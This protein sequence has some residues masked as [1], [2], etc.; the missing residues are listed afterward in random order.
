MNMRPYRMIAALLVLCV[1]AILVIQALWIN[2]FYSEKRESF[3]RS[4]YASLEQVARRLDERKGIQQI[5]GDLLTDST[6]IYRR[7]NHVEVRRV[8]S[9][10]GVNHEEIISTT[11]SAYS[12]NGS[13]DSVKKIMDEL[14][15][16]SP[17][18]IKK[19]ELKGIYGAAAREDKAKE[20]DID[21]L[22]N[23]MML[24]IKVL[25]V[26]ENN[27]DTLHNIIQRALANKGLF[28]PFE[29]LIK[30]TGKGRDTEVAR[31]KGYNPQQM[32]YTS[33]LSAD[34]IFNA[35][36]FVLLQFPAAGGFVLSG[37]RNMLLLSL[38][39]SMLV[40]G[41]FYYVM[42]LILKQKKLAEI[43]NDFINNMTH[44]LKTPIAT[45]GLAA[46]AMNHPEVR[47]STERFEG[48]TRILKEESRKL[49]GH[50]E[51]VLQMAMLDRGELQLHLES[52][53]VQ[54]LIREALRHHRLQIDGLRASVS[55]IEHTPGIK[56]SA[57]REHIQAVFNNLLDNALKYSRQPC[58]VEISIA[59]ENNRAVIR[60]R[61]NGI[62]IAANIQEKV[63]ERF[64]RAQGGN[65]H[66]VK[67][68]GL[69]LSYVRSIVEAHGGRVSL[70]S[71]PG[72]GSEFVLSFEV[73][74]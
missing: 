31:S 24:E 38:I 36:T 7:G 43:K 26:E 20:N 50:V 29:F 8:V 25:D 4:V 61:D 55:I 21:K 66:D 1:L 62:G 14:N 30:R 16:V 39:F 13:L 47:Q 59:I 58:L 72:K 42:R 22:V 44:E 67:G 23:K 5:K 28:L 53:N 32:S 45:I 68:F 52:L 34:K 54:Q 19:P 70:T 41:V 11:S 18:G 46:D 64:F 17:P 9:S 74:A 71:E 49:N 2:S 57:D 48:Y 51:R 27:V 65:L 63:F 6:K 3:D 56:I 15:V 73:H 40:I 37:M 33:D 69:G 12:G 60:F 35:N 10:S